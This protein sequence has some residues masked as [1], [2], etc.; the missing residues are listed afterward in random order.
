[1][2][3]VA[4]LRDRGDVTVAVLQDGRRISSRKAGAITGLRNGGKAAA[5]DLGNIGVIPVTRLH[6]GRA[7]AIAALIDGTIVAAATL[8]DFGR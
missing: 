2:V 7:Q 6:G 4:R 5:T 8:S 1:M 3:G